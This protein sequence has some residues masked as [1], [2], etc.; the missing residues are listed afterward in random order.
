M[1]AYRAFVNFYV[2]LGYYWNGIDVVDDTPPTI[3]FRQALESLFQNITIGL[4]SSKL[5]QYV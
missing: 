3:P 2:C 5:L 4:M 1:E